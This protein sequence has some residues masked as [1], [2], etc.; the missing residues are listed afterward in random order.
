MHNALSSAAPF[1]VT[2]VSRLGGGT[3]TLG[4]PETADWQLIL[5]YRGLHCPICRG[6]MEDLEP[7][8]SEFAEIGIEVVIVSADPVEKAEKLRADHA[9][10][11]PIGFDLSIAQMK[12]LGLYVSAPRTPQETDRPYAEPGLF[13]VNPE[14]HL[15]MVDISNAPFLRP[16]LDK[17][18]A[19][20]KFVLDNDHPIRGT[21]D[22]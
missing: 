13:L 16:E 10:T 6:Y 21:Y 5:V 12:M 11:V 4:K 22:G 17:L 19:R 9:P 3:L 20:I 14:G 2:T 8:L 7:R 1:P 15:H 18:P